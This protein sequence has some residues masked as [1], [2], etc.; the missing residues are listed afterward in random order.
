MDYL[1]EYLLQKSSL[2]SEI[3]I[4]CS[5]ALHLGI[6]DDEFEEILVAEKISKVRSWYKNLGMRIQTHRYHYITWIDFDKTF[7]NLQWKHLQ[8][9]YIIWENTRS[10]WVCFPTR[11]WVDISSGENIRL[12][13]RYQYSDLLF[14]SLVD[15]PADEDM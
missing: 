1:S 10:P 11:S 2:I 3:R 13:A 14:K 7:T 15:R 6:L 12:D 8:R 9:H 5:L 4:I